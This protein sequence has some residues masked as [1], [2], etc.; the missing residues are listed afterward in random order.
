MQTR[1]TIGNVRP[2]AT[3]DPRFDIARGNPSAYPHRIVAI[4]RFD[5]VR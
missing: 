3:T 2:P 4:R 1:P 5:G